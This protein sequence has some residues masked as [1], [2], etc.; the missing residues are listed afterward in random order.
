MESSTQMFDYMQILIG[1]YLLYAGITE[2]GAAYKDDTIHKTK[3]ADFKKYMRLFCFIGGPLSIISGALGIYKISP[4]NDIAY[5]LL[6]Y[7]VALI[8]IATYRMTD[9]YVDGLHK[10]EKPVAQS[11]A[12]NYQSFSK[13]AFVFGSVLYFV[14][15]IIMLFIH[16]NQV[17]LAVL[18]IDAIFIV[19]SIIIFKSF[20]EKTKKIRN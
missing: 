17:F 1:V 3:R 11:K 10:G 20:R 12:D 8:A 5:I 13:I 9:K 14:T 15:T 2:K 16:N 4:L 6:G 7:S 18:A 19:A